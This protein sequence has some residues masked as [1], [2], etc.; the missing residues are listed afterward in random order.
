MLT[1]SKIDDNLSIYHGSVV[2]FGSGSAGIRI[3]NILKSFGIEVVAFCDN[4]QSKWG[5][6]L[7]NLPIISVNELENLS[8]A[9][10]I[11]VQIGSTYEKDI[12]AQLEE[13]G[14]KNYITYS[15]AKNR[16][17]TLKYSRTFKNNFLKDKYM[18]SYDHKF[19]Y[20]RGALL[21]YLMS[22]LDNNLFLCLPTKTGDHSLNLTL[23][24]CGV[25]FY[26]LWHRPS[27]VNEECNYI[28]DTLGI[29]K[30]RMVTAVREPIS[31]NLSILYQMADDT[32]GEFSDLDENWKNGGDIQSLFKLWLELENYT[33]SY[34]GNKKYLYDVFREKYQT[35]FMIQKFFEV[36]AEHIGNILEYPFDTSRGYSVIKM[37]RYE[38]FVYQLEKLNQIEDKLLEW[39]GIPNAKL[40]NDNMGDEKWYAKSY[41]K[42]KQELKISKEYFK[43]CFDE[44]Y[45]KHFYNEH[46]IELFKNRWKNNIKIDGDL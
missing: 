37:G 41:Q 4:N 32:N 45:V 29:E 28:I 13:L 14:I 21:N 33:A 17:I 8:K 24:K 26:N 38:I 16:L 40:L 11:L 42:A 35:V 9:K 5:S 1:F 36:F 12:A 43:K 19:L 30:I 20:D 23:D 39:I 27:L 22:S 7:L 46:D 25:D 18:E 10:D 15:E 2:I 3:Y 44:P 34:S 6:S 31:Q